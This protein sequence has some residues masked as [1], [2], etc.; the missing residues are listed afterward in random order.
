MIN[1][2]YNYLTP[3]L[4]RRLRLRERFCRRAS[5]SSCDMGPSSA[6]CPS[7]SPAARNRLSPMPRG[8]GCSGCGCGDNPRG[9][10]RIF[11]VCRGGVGAGFGGCSTAGTAG[12][13]TCGRAV[14]S[15]RCASSFSGVCWRSV[16]GAGAVSFG[17]SDARSAWELLNNS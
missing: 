14:A 17:N 7:R 5:N 6:S 12:G 16:A 8:A 4:L 10:V 1:I 13:T 9:S 2:H 11:S 3:Y 15:G